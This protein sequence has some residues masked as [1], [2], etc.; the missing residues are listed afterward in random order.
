MAVLASADNLTDSIAD[1]NIFASFALDTPS[2]FRS[3][4][5]LSSQDQASLAE[6]TRLVEVLT[7]TSRTA[8]GEKPWELWDD[9][10]FW[11]YINGTM[12]GHPWHTFLPQGVA[13]GKLMLM[14][15]RGEEE[16]QGRMI[17]SFGY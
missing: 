16:S 10:L 3:Q 8:Q 13:H 9:V 12:R 7:C 1:S 6:E 4:P 11:L 2:L 14:A 5:L 17:E 15:R